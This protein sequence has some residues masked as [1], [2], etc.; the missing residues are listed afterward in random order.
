[1]DVNPVTVAELLLGGGSALIGSASLALQ[2]YDRRPP[3]VVAYPETATVLAGAGG[4][5]VSF[6]AKGPGTV[7]LG[8]NL[9]RLQGVRLPP[10]R[11]GPWRPQGHGPVVLGRGDCECGASAI[12][13]WMAHIAES[14]PYRP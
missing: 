2:L 9:H 5:T 11:V 7:S 3:S 4:A 6:D 10:Q 13:D 1:M 14:P 8:N 12:T